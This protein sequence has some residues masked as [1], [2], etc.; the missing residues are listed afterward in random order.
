LKIQNS[1]T[2]PNIFRPRQI[3]FHIFKAAETKVVQHFRFGW[4]VLVTFDNLQR[5]SRKLTWFWGFK[6]GVLVDL[7]KGANSPLLE[8]IIKDQAELNK[9]TKDRKPASILVFKIS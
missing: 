2:D 6:R 9:V 8:K 3:K 5:N 1:S 4:Y 7:V